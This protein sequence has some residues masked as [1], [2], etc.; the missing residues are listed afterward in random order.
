MITNEIIYRCYND[1]LKDFL[2][3]NNIKYFLV[4]R[5]IVTGH[6]FYAFEKTTALL[7]MLKKW[8]ENNPKYN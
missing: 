7:D 3:K 2:R 6:K 4:A 8:E 5:D 1:Y